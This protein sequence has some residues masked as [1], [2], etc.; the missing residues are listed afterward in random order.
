[1]QNYKLYFNIF[2]SNK[3]IRTKYIIFIKMIKMNGQTELRK[4][5]RIT[6]SVYINKIFIELPQDLN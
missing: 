2:F 6:T 4:S 5:T 1:M 3:Q